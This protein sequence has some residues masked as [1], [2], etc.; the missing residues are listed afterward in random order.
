MSWIITESIAIQ[1]SEIRRIEQQKKEIPQMQIPSFDFTTSLPI[2][3]ADKITTVKKSKSF[4]YILTTMDNKVIELT[5]EDYG[6]IRFQLNDA[7][8]RELEFS[9]Y[10]KDHLQYKPGTSEFDESLKHYYQETSQKQNDE[11]NKN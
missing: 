1:A 8:A 10:V 11:E 6:E 3:S 9:R 7:N 4:K 2:R 5:E